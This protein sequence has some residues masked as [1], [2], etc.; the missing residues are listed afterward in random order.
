MCGR[1]RSCD[2][3]TLSCNLTNQLVLIDTRTASLALS[4]SH[5][6]KLSIALIVENKSSYYLFR[7]GANDER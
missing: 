7:F 3:L 2:L 6:L 4:L 1:K 5:E